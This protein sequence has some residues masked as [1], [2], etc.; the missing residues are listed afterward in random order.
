MENGGAEIRVDNLEP[1][2]IRYLET[3]SF[4]NI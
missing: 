2:I 1:K 3:K 4:K